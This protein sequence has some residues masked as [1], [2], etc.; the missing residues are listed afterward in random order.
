MMKSFFYRFR[1]RSFFQA[2][3][4]GLRLVPIT[5][6]CILL[7]VFLFLA[8]SSGAYDIGVREIM[9]VLAGHI[10]G[11]DA[12]PADRLQDTIIWKIRLPRVLLAA[13]VGAALAFSGAVF[14]GCFRNPLVD[15]YILGISSGAAFGAALGIVMPAFPLSV[16]ALAFGFAFAAVAAAWGLSRHNGQTPVIMLILAGIIIGSVFSAF[17]GILKYLAEDAALREIVF[18]LM[19]GFYY[20]GWRDVALV[21]PVVAVIFVLVLAFSWQLN[22]LS[23]GDTEARSLGVAPEPFKLFFIVS[24]TLATAVAVSAVGII[25]WVGLMMPHAARLMIGPD[26]RF[27]IPMA[28]LLGALYLVFCDT[29]ARILVSAEIPIGIITSLA[30]APYLFYLLRSKGVVQ[31]GGS[32]A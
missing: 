32:H 25:P 27:L 23:M 30:G 3:P 19:G 20:A 14:Q 24:A 28:A 22:I 9:A 15:P 16:Q 29:L 18:W 7:V 1:L 21:A 31:P 8:L 10:P 26:N 11:V 4:E 13:T 2:G 5:G 12:G 6:L 17:V